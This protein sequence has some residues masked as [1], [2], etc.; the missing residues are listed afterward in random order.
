MLDKL[1]IPIYGIV[2][3]MSHVI[4]DRC[5]S[6][7]YIFGENTEHLANQLELPILESFELN[8]TVSN[9]TA[10]GKPVVLSEPDSKYAEHYKSLA[11]KIYSYLKMNKVE[12]Q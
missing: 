10:N 4:C 6:K 11:N 9:S 12:E 5:G 2:E 8:Q 7:N 3:N 1:N